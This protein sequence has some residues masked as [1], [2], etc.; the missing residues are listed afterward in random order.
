MTTAARTLTLSGSGGKI[1]TNGQIVNL[2][3]GSTVTGTALEKLGTGTLNLAGT[4]T[5]STLTATDGTTNVNSALG[6]GTSTVNANATTNFSFSQT[7]AAL[8]IGDGV[9]VTFGDGLPFAPDPGKNGGLGTPALVPEPG[10]ATLL[11]GASGLL[12]L[13]RRRA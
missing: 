5:Y 7:L 10:T 11:L 13:R 12:G 3:A 4:Q 1:D 8:N 9:E 2:N 6:T